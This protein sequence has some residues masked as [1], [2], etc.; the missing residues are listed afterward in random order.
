MKVTY[1]G[2]HLF[3]EGV[4]DGEVIFRNF[5]GRERK[6]QHG[7]IYNDEGQRNFNLIIPDEFLDLFDEN[8]ARIKFTKDRP[9]EKF[10]KVNVYTDGRNKPRLGVLSRDKERIRKYDEDQYMMLDAMYI[11]SVDFRMHF[12]GK[13]RDGKR[14][15]Y[16]DEAVFDPHRSDYDRKWEDKWEDDTSDF[17]PNGPDTADEEEQ[18]F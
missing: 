8:D 6:G 15:L 4:K 5:A 14:S 18:P 16:L 9:E 2:R 10:V 13:G 3:V 11:N 17:D 7:E 1:D 12:S